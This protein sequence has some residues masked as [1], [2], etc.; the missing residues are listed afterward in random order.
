[1]QA[2]PGSSQS[3]IVLLHNNG[4]QYDAAF[5]TAATGAATANAASPIAKASDGN[6]TIALKTDTAGDF[7][8]GSTVTIAN[9][10]PSGSG[11]LDLDETI[12]V[13]GTV[14]TARV[15]HTDVN[16]APPNGCA[17]FLKGAPLSD[18]TVGSTTG[19]V[20]N[21][22]LKNPG[23]SL[24]AP[25]SG[26]N[27]AVHFPAALK[28]TGDT[29]LV[30]NV[31]V[32]PEGLV[33]EPA[34]GTNNTLTLNIAS[35]AANVGIASVGTKNPDNTWNL[36]APLGASLALGADLAGLS[37][38]VE[39]NAATGA[40]ATTATILA[41]TTTAAGT[42]TMAWRN[43]NPSEIHATSL[44]TGA[45]FT[46][47]SRAAAAGAPAGSAATSAL[48]T[49]LTAGAAATGSLDTMTMTAETG[50]EGPAVPLDSVSDL[51]IVT[52]GPTAGDTSA[53]LTPLAAPAAAR[54]SSA[55]V[56]P[57]PGTMALLAAALLGLAVLG[58]RRR[59]A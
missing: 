23:N 49:E 26:G 15:F 27:Y 20:T 5:T 24:V 3:Q 56:V 31:D 14:V 25:D 29:P 17:N 13:K 51:S 1:M 48:L 52:L 22:R 21:P 50:S 11:S 37:S 2:A 57:E 4:G 28:L 44:P 9:A 36:G 40:L 59:K 54:S 19:V 34:Y 7:T 18:V 12:A 16:V 53:G 47:A 45:R 58:L 30:A 10:K 6:L 43:R 55:A 38:S 33:N 46:P 39:A 35:S 8:T 41:G 32:E 42:V